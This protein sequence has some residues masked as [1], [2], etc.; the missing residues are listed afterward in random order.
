ML[1]NDFSISY[2]DQMSNYIVTLVKDLHDQDGHIWKYSPLARKDSNSWC[3][4]LMIRSAIAFNS[5]VH[6][7]NKSL[8]TEEKGDKVR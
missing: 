4:M 5:I 7:L 1:I 6:S 2:A 8:S 3:R